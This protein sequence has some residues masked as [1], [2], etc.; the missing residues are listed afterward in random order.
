LSCADGY[1][2]RFIV[3][4]LIVS[5]LKER[6]IG[7]SMMFIVPLVVIRQAGGHRDQ[8]RRSRRTYQQEREERLGDLAGVPWPGVYGEWET[9]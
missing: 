7:F 4:G 9:A 1:S 3:S 2:D 8:R 6:A 5:G